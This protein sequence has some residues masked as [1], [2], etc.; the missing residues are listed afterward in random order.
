MQV[1]QEGG[2]HVTA[3][4]NEN[5]SKALLALREPRRIS[6]SSACYGQTMTSSALSPLPE[7]VNDATRSISPFRVQRWT[8][9]GSWGIALERRARLTP[10]EALRPLSIL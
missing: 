7:G 3:S 6:S 8:M 4:T 2:A 9:V 1:T 10:P 5:V